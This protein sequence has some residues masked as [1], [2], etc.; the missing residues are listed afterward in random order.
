MR[1]ALS[2]L[3]LDMK[4]PSDFGI[5]T[6]PIEHGNSF[7]ENALV[8]ARYF[9][10]KSKTPT[11]ADDSGIMVKALENELGIHTRRCGA[12]PLASDEEWITY[13]LDRMRGEKNKQATFMCVMAFID[14]SGIEHLFEGRCN[15]VIT[16]TLEAEYLPGLPVSAC[17][18]PDGYGA[19][20]SAMNLVQKNRTSHRGK[21]LH[22]VRDF[23]ALRSSVSK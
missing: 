13:F 14:Q 23:L 12:G 20:F 1:E 8:K 18:R 22:Q 3:G 19:V 10:G 21:A 7:E 15:G 6:S 16:E 17:F 9:F 4:I 2:G 11:L 5:T